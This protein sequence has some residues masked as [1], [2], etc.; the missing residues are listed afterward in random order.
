MSMGILWVQM[1]V[2]L[3]PWERP[4]YEGKDQLARGKNWYFSPSLGRTNS[5]GEGPTHE[6]KDQLVRGKTIGAF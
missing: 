3:S 4:D 1:W 2:D 5:R 6:G